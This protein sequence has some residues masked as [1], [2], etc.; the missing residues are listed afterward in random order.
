MRRQGRREIKHSQHI[1]DCYR[2]PRS[3]DR[4]HVNGH[5]SGRKKRV[6]PKKGCGKVGTRRCKVNGQGTPH[7]NVSSDKDKERLAG[8][9]DGQ[10]ANGKRASKGEGQGNWKR[11]I[12]KDKQSGRYTVRREAGHEIPNQK[13][14]I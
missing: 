10:T 12:E 3:F 2:I 7:R 1:I 11:D 13:T 14:A 5:V 4:V 9:R 6:R 8:Q